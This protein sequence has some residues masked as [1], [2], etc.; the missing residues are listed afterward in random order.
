MNIEQRRAL[1]ASE[2]EAAGDPLDETRKQEKSLLE[3]LRGTEKFVKAFL[4][5]VVGTGLAGELAGFKQAQAAEGDKNQTEI[6]VH[7][8]DAPLLDVVSQELPSN[9]VENR[10]QAT[11]LKEAIDS[12]SAKPIPEGTVVYTLDQ[13]QQGDQF[14]EQETPVSGALPTENIAVSSFVGSYMEYKGK[15]GT[16]DHSRREVVLS[17]MDVDLQPTGR[18]IDVT[19]IG[20]TP[21]RATV[22]ALQ[23]AAEYFQVN[24]QSVVFDYQQERTGD[25]VTV[26]TEHSFSGVRTDAQSYIDS[27]TVVEPPQ[28]VDVNGQTY[29]EVKLQVNQG[30]VQ[31]SNAQDT[32][33]LSFN[34]I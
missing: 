18:S 11:R 27:Y 16:E 26:N 25:G 7:D 10:Q 31:P 3:R 15:L 4:L 34:T 20:D 22:S 19:G 5:C 1:P 14:N 17:Q 23:D 9:S 13:S 28:Q 24:V 2:K 32:S 8:P 29:W 33:H 12:A 30:A 6:T 21:E